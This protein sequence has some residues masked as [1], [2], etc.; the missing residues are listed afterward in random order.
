[1]TRAHISPE[2]MAELADDTPRPD[3]D[4][5]LQ[6]VASCGQCAAV[7]AELVHHRA[8]FIGGDGVA[9]T[10]ADW[11]RL[12]LEIPESVAARTSRSSEPPLRDH[13]RSIRVLLPVAVVVI[14]IATGVW[15]SQPRHR[16][17]PSFVVDTA[18]AVEQ[19]MAEEPLDVAYS[20]LVAT[21]G[22]TVRNGGSEAIELS[23]SL[24]KLADYYNHE[25]MTADVA[26]WLIGGYIATG[27][28]R[29]AEVYM[30][31]ALEK[32]PADGRMH[33]LAGIL[34]YK[35]SDLAVAEQHF[36]AAIE[37][38]PRD[39]IAWFNLG[40]L[41]TEQDRLEEAGP[42]LSKAGELLRGTPLA[43]RASTISQ[44]QR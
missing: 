16:A 25:R 33:R 10:N 12:G 31:E 34:A 5:L 40:T 38:T 29:N 24:A 41:L 7:Y 15:L 1:M 28:M 19:R 35:Q 26:Y 18:H 4:A 8:N 44:N 30:G 32:F 14:A 20:T 23:T 13:R 37:A 42:A 11:V 36:R 17:H 9:T 43:S 3:R 21:S 27:Q 22:A 39:G 2:V 6:H